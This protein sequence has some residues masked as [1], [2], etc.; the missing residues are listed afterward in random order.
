MPSFKYRAVSA[1]N[2]I[3]EGEMDAPSRAIVIERIR[4]LGHVPLE[5]RESKHGF[6]RSRFRLSTKKA[7]SH[8]DVALV[9]HELSTLLEA[10]VPL[11][12][13]FETLIDISQNERTRALLSEILE[14]LRSGISLANAL[15]DHKSIF[16]PYYASMVRAGEASG[17]LATVL[18]RLSEFLDKSQKLRENIK[19]AL[20]YPIFLMVMAVGSIFIMLRFVVPEFKPIFDSA[21]ESLPTSTK[22]LIVVGDAVGEYAWLALIIIG[23]AAVFFYRYVS[24]KEGRRV[25]DGVLLRVPLIGPI[26]IKIEVARFTRTAASLLENGVGLI[27]TL[28]IVRDTLTNTVVASSLD[29]VAARAKEG[30]GLANPLHETRLYPKLLVHLIRVG[31]ETGKLDEMLSKVADIY[32]G[33]IARTTSRMMS[34]LAPVLT[35]VMGLVIAGIMVSIMT[36]IFSV[37]NVAF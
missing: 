27:Q 5:A 15:N 22:V 6:K 19:T 4:G 13:A 20:Y 34:M 35:I 17:A 1:S 23:S 8:R 10:G 32:D 37:N 12:R 7:V 18:N 30:G 14:R 21:G 31:E 36:A 16:P 29:D 3:I 24:T 9:T 33:E 26:I 28:T 2:Q 25:V 11:D